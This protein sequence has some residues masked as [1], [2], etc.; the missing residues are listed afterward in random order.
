ML[1]LLLWFKFSNILG[2]FV[3]QL[4]HPSIHVINKKA[5]WRYDDQSQEV[6][7]ELLIEIL[8]FLVPKKNYQ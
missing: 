3:Y 1:S 2:Y 5:L 6:I 4:P 7:G 8:A